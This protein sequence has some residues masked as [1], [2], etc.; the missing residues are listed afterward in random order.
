M[1]LFIFF[2]EYFSQFLLDGGIFYYLDI[3]DNV[4]F[5][6]KKRWIFIFYV[7]VI[8][9]YETGFFVGEMNKESDKNFIVLVN[10]FVNMKREEI[11]FDRFYFILG[12]KLKI[13]YLYFCQ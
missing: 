2:V 6:Y 1:F 13:I 12:I 3:V 4:K 10:V 7:L 8:W 5:Y 9:F 11:N